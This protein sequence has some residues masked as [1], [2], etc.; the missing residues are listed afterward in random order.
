MTLTRDEVKSAV[1]A[2]VGMEPDTVPDDENLV[3]LGLDSLAMMGLVNR[4]RRQGVVIEFERLVASPTVNSWV[5]YLCGGTA[6][7]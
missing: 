5:E 1:A 3:A 6:I 2:A 7:A 4:W